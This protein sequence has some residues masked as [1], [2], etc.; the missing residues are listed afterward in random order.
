M[1]WGKNLNEDA[2]ITNIGP[3]QPNTLQP[4]VGFGLKREYGVTLSGKF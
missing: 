4:A 3:N 1:F 2:D